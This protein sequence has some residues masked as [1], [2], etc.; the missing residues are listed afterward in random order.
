MHSTKMDE[1]AFRIEICELA[2]LP[3]CTLTLQFKDCTVTN[4]R[5]RHNLVYECE[6][7]SITSAALM[8]NQISFP[9]TG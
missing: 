7:M 6:C 9:L 2:A 8:K 4:G 3:E 1:L 5:E